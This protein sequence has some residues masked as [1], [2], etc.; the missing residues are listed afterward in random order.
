MVP[1]IEPTVHH[2]LHTILRLAMDCWK[3]NQPSSPTKF[4][5]GLMF[6]GLSFLLMA[7]P[8]ALYG[9]NG[10]VSPLWLVGSWALVISVKC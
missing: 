1:I 6:A 4:A 8:G 2:A 5:V 10:K 3:K 7:I 9:T